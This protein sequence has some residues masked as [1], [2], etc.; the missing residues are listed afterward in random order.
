MGHGHG[1]RAELLIVGIMSY[2]HADVVSFCNTAPHPT[3]AGGSSDGAGLR[4]CV[5]VTIS[6]SDG[7]VCRTREHFRDSFGTSNPFSETFSNTTQPFWPHKSTHRIRRNHRASRCIGITDVVMAETGRV[8][9]IYSSVHEG[10]G[11]KGR[12]TRVL[13]QKGL[14]PLVLGGPVPSIRDLPGL[15]KADVRL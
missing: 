3:V 15:P 1:F 10:C 2:F 14:S 8:A 4:Q 12:N 13:G 6:D 7:I 11:R 9:A 5:E